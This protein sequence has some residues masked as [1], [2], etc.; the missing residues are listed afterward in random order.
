M[1]NLAKLMQ[2]NGQ[3]V[4]LDLM[5]KTYLRDAS[6]NLTG[7]SVT[8]GTDTWVKTYTRDEN[9]LIIGESVWV[10]Q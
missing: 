8:N 5:P 10:K 4:G 7:I 2:Q 3:I 1:S 6:G 9:D